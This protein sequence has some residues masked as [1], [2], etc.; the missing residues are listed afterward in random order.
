[1]RT[2]ADAVRAMRAD[3]GMSQQAF[4]TAARLSIRAIAKYES[5]RPVALASVLK[6]HGLAV[7][8]GMREWRDLWW[9]VIVKATLDNAI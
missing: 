8:N 2:A 6:L 5:G 7:R 1:M 9:G 4:A 3:S